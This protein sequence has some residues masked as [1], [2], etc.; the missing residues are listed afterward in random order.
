MPKRLRK[1][2]TDVNQLAH[3]IVELSTQEEEPVRLSAGL[4]SQVMSEMGRKG[5]RIG[6]KRRLKTLTPERRSRIALM[7]ANARWKKK[8]Q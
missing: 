3:K 5:G 2:P 7:A 4:V 6:G 1:M 8:K